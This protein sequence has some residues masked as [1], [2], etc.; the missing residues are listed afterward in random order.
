MSKT[1]KSKKTGSKKAAGATGS[2]RKT[3]AKERRSTAYPKTRNKKRPEKLSPD[4]EVEVGKLLSF[5]KKH[6]WLAEISSLA[7]MLIC[8]FVTVSFI[9][10]K[11]DSNTPNIF[12]PVGHFIETLVSG[13]M[14]WS[15]FL[16]LGILATLAVHIWSFAAEKD[17]DLKIKIDSMLTFVIGTLAL[18][19]A[20]ATLFAIP[21][22]KAGG[23][24]IGSSISEPLVR[25]TSS[26]GAYLVTAVWSL[27]AVACIFQKSTRDVLAQT[28][29]YVLDIFRLVFYF[30]SAIFSFISGTILGLFKS[31]D[32]IELEEENEI[33]ATKPRLRRN[34]LPAIEEPIDDTE[35]E[36][37]HVLVQRRNR[38]N[39]SKKASGALRVRAKN[40]NLNSSL[41]YV[42][43]SLS[44]L[45]HLEQEISAEDDEV[46]RQKSYMI[47]Q[48]LKDFGIMG[49]V[50]EVHPG[51]VITLFEFEPAPGVKV[52]KIAALQDDLAM[53]LKASAIRIIAPLP[54]KG[55]VG[56]E[57][58]NKNREMVQLRD[59]LESET[60]VNASSQLTIALGKD[61]YGDP[62]VVDIA[63]MPHLL[64]A[65]ATGTGKS[66]CINTL[67]LSLLYRC[68]P[69]ELGLILIDPKILELSVYDGIP[70]L[71]VPVVT[72]PKQAKAV[73]E[74]AVKEMDKRYRLM[75]RFG[76]RSIKGYNQLVKGEIE[77]E[78]SRKKEQAAEV[79]AE[80]DFFEEDFDAYSDDESVDIS[81]GNKRTI[82]AEKLEI[83]S[84]IVIVIDELA[85]LMLSVGKEI[86]DLIAR[87]AQKA[88]AAGIHL[89][90]ATQRPSVDV[91]TGL[92]KANF[93]A[94]LS[95]RVS[96]RVDSRTILDSMGAE[97]LLGRGDMLYMLPGQIHIS[98]A[99]GAFVSDDDVKKVIDAI[100]RQSEPN[101]DSEIMNMCEAALRDESSS[102]LNSIEDSDYDSLYDQAV[103]FVLEKGAASTSLLQRAF[104]I[105]YN[106]AAR[107]ID[108]MEREGIIG[109]VNGAK[110][111][112]ILINGYEAED[113][114]IA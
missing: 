80:V 32:V 55:T 46:L 98:R 48:K 12:G 67:L 71:K 97:K 86:E 10:T 53:S 73:L 102:D 3:A 27:I 4:K 92:I 109:P 107:I 72:V 110:P 60:F 44:L 83:M 74:W 38:E 15:F 65:G 5:M 34:R 68:T 18:T 43:P 59:V 61:T 13:F 50:T 30:V 58:P 81:V 112:E 101:Y 105:G 103:Q 57:V 91:I 16:P 2:K 14:G 79:E 41:P 26:T 25:Y 85:D 88:R 47:E 93:P 70:H 87:L 7:L 29:S 39:F 63:Q 62:I 75:Q 54:R 77:Q 78:E 31:S 11:I 19:V 45:E 9:S 24:D 49:R 21:W 28:L 33:V 82:A 113:Q 6:H 8:V 22:G 89:I 114:E 94:R 36:V 100:K 76:V 17:Q 106:R 96:S 111:R 90:V 95:F 1:K 64:V 84:N 40:N 23:G 104:R 42:P 56:I 66:V 35:P 51:P 20:S 69:D 99:H 37:T 52:G 108:L